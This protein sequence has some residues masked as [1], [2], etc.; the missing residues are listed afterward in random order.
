MLNLIFNTLGFLLIPTVFL[1]GSVGV[2][3]YI[4]PN[5]TKNVIA[6]KSWEAT[7]F[8][9]WSCDE[10]KKLT[11]SDNEYDGYTA[12]KEYP[13]FDIHYNNLLFLD[14]KNNVCITDTSNSET[15]VN[16]LKFKPNPVFL[17]KKN[18]EKI[19]YKRINITNE[20]D[21]YNYN[22]NECSESPFLQVEYIDKNRTINFHDYLKPF[23]V[24][25][26]ILFDDNFTRFF[27]KYFF[28]T[29]PS[30]SYIIK[31]FDKDINIIELKKNETVIITN[32]NNLYD[33]NKNRE[34]GYGTFTDSE[35]DG[36][37]SSNH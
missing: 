10:L 13:E 5:R 24:E 15:L 27:L 25:N 28:D 16:I 23:Y 8:Y 14:N 1:V 20:Q 12:D 37:G 17:Q 21:L 6:N 11:L 31:I 9:V 32:K 33:I 35:S 4:D 22:F 2:C 36:S 29:E 34:E 3:Y 19:L 7:K 26:N 18:K 30:D